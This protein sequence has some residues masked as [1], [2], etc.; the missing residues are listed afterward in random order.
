MFKNN[1]LLVRSFSS[2]FIVGILLS[3]IYL[4]NFS[5]SLLFILNIAIL[6]A[7]EWNEITKNNKNPLKWCFLG[8]GYI[9]LTVLPIFILKEYPVF[10]GLNS[11]HL[12]MWLFI[13]VWSI[14]TFAYIIGKTLNLGK[15]KITKISP[16]KSYEGLIGGIIG[17]CVICYIFANHFLPEI[18]NILLF[19][20][21]F[22]CI[23]EQTSDIAESY[24]KRKFNVKDSGNIIPGH[25]GFL[26]R[27][28]G[29]LFTTPFLI[30]FLYFTIYI[31]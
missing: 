15:H 11:N 19:L 14:D 6:M 9:S 30:I 28:D 13:L 12:L 24:I 4:F 21:P 16:K 20:T 1:E 3:F 17:A 7:Y 23:I 25:G 26:D 18:K 27:F 10:L 22:L 2:I 31:I 5:L 29:F 8:M